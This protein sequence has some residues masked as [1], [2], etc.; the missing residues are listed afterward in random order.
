M[1]AS[2]PQYWNRLG[3]SKS[4]TLDQQELRKELILDMMMQ[5]PEGTALILPSPME[6]APHK[7]H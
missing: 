4:C 7:V 1:T 2:A 5:V 3:T 6:A